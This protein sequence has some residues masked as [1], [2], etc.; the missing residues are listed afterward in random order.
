MV[1]ELC[2]TIEERLPI[3]FKREED[4]KGPKTAVGNNGHVFIDSLYI[5]LI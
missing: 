2:V 5:C 3:D 1:E 4:H